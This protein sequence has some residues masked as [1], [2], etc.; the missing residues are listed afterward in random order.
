MTATEVADDPALTRCGKK[1][2]L[3]IWRVENFKLVAVPPQQHGSFYEGDAYLV[4][5]TTAS[6]TGSGVRKD[7]QN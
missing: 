6:R 4:L 2:G 7:R 1:A 3:E 5:K